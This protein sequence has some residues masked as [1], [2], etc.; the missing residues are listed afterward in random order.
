MTESMLKYPR[1][2]HIQGSRFQPGDED[3]K[4]VPLSQIQDRPLVIEEKMDGANSGISFSKTGEL[5]LQSRGHFLFGGHREKHFNLFKQWAGALQDRLYGVLKDRYVMYG[6][7]LYAKHTVFYNNLP[8]YF[9]EFDILDK[10]N[11]RFLDTQTRKKKL[12]DLPIASVSVLNEGSVKSV[13]D[14]HN[15]LG[16]SGFILPDAF[17]V[18][19]KECLQRGLDFKRVSQETDPTFQMEGLYIKVE[20]EGEV[21]E[22]YKFIRSSFLTSV[23]NSGGHWL[24]RPIIPN[25]LVKDV[26]LFK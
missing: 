25:Q 9:M 19:Q 23:L 4:S 8:H 20:E 15:L 13:L 2:H 12:K 3:L 10:S 6:E 18:L 14:L 24:N 11:G 21:K 7:W 26:E 5:L 1:T 16:P 22:R 17:E